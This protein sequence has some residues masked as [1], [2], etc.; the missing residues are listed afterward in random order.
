[1]Y[2]PYAP[3][4]RVEKGAACSPPGPFLLSGQTLLHQMVLGRRDCLTALNTECPTTYVKPTDE[5]R[6]DLWGLKRQKKILSPNP[7]A[8]KKRFPLP[9]PLPSPILSDLFS[10]VSFQPSD[11]KR[12]S[13]KLEGC[14]VLIWPH[15]GK[16]SSF[17]KEQS[18]D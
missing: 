16:G 18:Q 6:T 5:L 7:N 11:L 9:M 13:Q 17:S 10:R 8:T 1:M 2:L 14:V 15:C 3:W 4:C 12:F